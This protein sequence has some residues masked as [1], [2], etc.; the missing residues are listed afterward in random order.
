MIGKMQCSNIGVSEAI[1]SLKS[2][3]ATHLPI[4]PAKKP[5]KLEVL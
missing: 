2:T 1:L 3:F 4:P 5:P